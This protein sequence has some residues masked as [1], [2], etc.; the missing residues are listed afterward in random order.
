M[1]P[2]LYRFAQREL[3]WDMEGNIVLSQKRLIR[4]Q[5]LTPRNYRNYFNVQSKNPDMI[6]VPVLTIDSHTYKLFGFINYLNSRFIEKMC[7][8]VEIRVM[9]P[10]CA[11]ARPCIREYLALYNISESEYSQNSAYKNWQ[12]SQQYINVKNH[13]NERNKQKHNS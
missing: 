4:P 7:D 2:H 1:K 13:S 5:T 9:P 12:R 10:V 6:L 11:E 3:K 8:Y